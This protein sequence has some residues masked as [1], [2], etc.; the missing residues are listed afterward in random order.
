MRC[1]ATGTR[2]QRAHFG[3][4]VWLGGSL[5]DSSSAAIW[6]L[7]SGS[8]HA[9]WF[10]GGCTLTDGEAP[11]LTTSGAPAVREVFFPASEV[12]IVD[13]WES[14]GLRGTASHD[15]TVSEVFVPEHRTFWFTE[16]PCVDHPLY[17]MPVVGTFATYLAAVPLGIASCA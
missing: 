8:S 10:L 7:G 16:A 15:D 5:A 13:T 1:T 3:A 4:R 11:L 12:Q 6:Q 14:T 17:W 2:S 9:S